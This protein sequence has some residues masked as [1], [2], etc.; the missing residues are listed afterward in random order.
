MPID[1]Q[2]DAF[3]L[4]LLVA[5]NIVNVFAAANNTVSISVPESSS[6]FVAIKSIAVANHAKLFDPFS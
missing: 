2:P 5:N 3:N 1:K 6:G 4:R